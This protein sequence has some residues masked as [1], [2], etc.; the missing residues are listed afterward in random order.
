VTH[1]DLIIVGA[2]MAGSALATALSRQSGEKKTGRP[3]S[4]AIIEKRPLPADLSLLKKV[5]STGGVQG[6]DLRASAL[7][8]STINWLDEIGVWPQL[9]DLRTSRFVGMDVWVEDGTGR[10]QFEA[11]EV[12]STALGEVVE[13]RLLVGV[14]LEAAV[15][16]HNVK[17][18]DDAE[19]TTLQLPVGVGDATRNTVNETGQVVI[20]LADGSSLSAELL[21]AA[22]GANSQIRELAGIDVRRWDYGHDAI[23]CTVEME[24]PHRGI[25]YQ[26]FMRTGP[27]AFL[28]LE[29]DDDDSRL[30]TIVWSQDCAQ[31]AELMSLDDEAFG[32]ELAAAI[33]YR[34]GSVLELG[35]RQ[36]F[37][38]KQ[39]HA[40]D[41]QKS[42]VV[43]VADAAHTIH[44]LAGQG[45]NLGLADVAE[46]SST[47]REAMQAGKSIADETL[48]KRY[49][50]RRKTD[51][52]AMMALMEAFKQVYQPLP[53]PAM[54]LRNEGMKL[55]DRHTM[56]KKKVI[57]YAMGVEGH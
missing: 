57:Q 20:E 14:F 19:V 48:L 15:A 37:P 54:L 40:I 11:A 34:L 32:E 22:D 44:P 43:L 27:A 36:S 50:R 52:L 6:Y 3:L 29:T 24:K 16:S 35:S 31:A 49:Q 45:I 13:N 12:G 21:V 23:V 42:G 5:D 25:A 38:L 55:L 33:E 47:I 18:Y 26:R 53:L 2:G 56:I 17:V 28:P 4:I 41:Y 10:I 7:T 8:A 51:N 39:M 30:C 9:H 1:Y 46:L